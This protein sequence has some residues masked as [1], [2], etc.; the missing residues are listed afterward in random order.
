MMERL[1]LPRNFF[2]MMSRDAAAER[3][4]HPP[5]NAKTLRTLSR[6]VRFSWRHA[7]VADEIGTFLQEHD[8]QLESYRRA[9]WASPSPPQLL[10][11]AEEL[12]GLYSDT[13]WYSFIGQ[14]NM[15]GRNRMVTRMVEQHAPEV[16]PTDV[17][18]GLTG[19]KSLE[20]NE[21]LQRLA[22]QARELG[23][24][25][26]TLLMEGEEERIRAELA[27]TPGGQALADEVDRF[28]DRFGFMSASGTDLSR[29]P[30]SEDATIIWRSIG[31]LAAQPVRPATQDAE[32][33]RKEAQ[34]C[35]REKL[36]PPQ[37]YAFDRLLRSTITYVDLRE[38]ISFL[39]SEDSYHLRRVYLALADRL[40]AAGHLTQQD[41]VFF[42]S[43]DEVSELVQGHL[44]PHEARDRVSAHR[45]EMA[46]DAELDLPDT[47]YGSYV[48]ARPVARA[49]GEACLTGIGG[50]SGLA[51]GYAR[52]VLDPVQVQFALASDDIL[53]IPFADTSWTPLF[54]G[55]GGVVAETGGQLCHSAIVAREYGLPAVVNVKD[56]TRL[57]QEGQGIVV[58]G[59]RG[60]VILKEV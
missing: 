41:D 13:M 25:V 18:R 31:R 45:A 2:E 29:T 6:L 30:W 53:V 40:V 27:T 54:C 1:G 57:I 11:H 12:A 15:M 24:T 22:A 23:P 43:H 38:Q 17:L 49:A 34:A 36:S 46:A 3:P 20:T 28:L 32:A 26:P 39:L 10:E 42:L 55:V 44:P 9:D 21:G 37:R 48:P 52:I 7:R 16:P 58:D 19:L 50:S 35:L 8:R 56:A 4:G 47:I 51:E 5:L 60:C 33:T 59:N 14:L